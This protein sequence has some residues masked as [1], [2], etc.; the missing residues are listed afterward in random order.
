MRNFICKITSN[1]IDPGFILTPFAIKNVVLRS[2]LHA[3]MYYVFGF[4]ILRMGL[5]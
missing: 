2:D 1:H 3:R 4:R 5:Y